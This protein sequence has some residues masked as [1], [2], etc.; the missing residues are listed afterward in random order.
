MCQKYGINPVFISIGIAAGFV[1]TPSNDEMAVTVQ[2]RISEKGIANAISESCGIDASNNM[3][4]MV[5]SFYEMFKQ[6]AD[7]KKIIEEAESIKQ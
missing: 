3:F 4:G 5:V 6:G 2:E 7:L 1:F